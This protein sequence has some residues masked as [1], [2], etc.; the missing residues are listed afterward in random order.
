MSLALKALSAEKPGPPVM[1]CWDGSQCWDRLYLGAGNPPGALG[2]EP[3]A[4]CPGCPE[5][6]P[7][8]PE[9]PAWALALTQRPGRPLGDVVPGQLP[10][11]Q[12]LGCLEAES[13]FSQAYRGLTP[14]S[15]KVPR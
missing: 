12:V 8:G 11:S 14:L 9:L 13:Q 7:A 1:T 15:P 2:A 4:L 10:F 3:T 5:L 6:G